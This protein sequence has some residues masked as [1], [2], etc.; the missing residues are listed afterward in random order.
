M[1]M[2]F[3]GVWGP[4]LDPVRSTGTTTTSCHVVRWSVATFPLAMNIVEMC[5]IMSPIILNYV[6][7]ITCLE[8]HLF[9][10]G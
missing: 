7:D 4:V 8:V 3:F 6:D 2:T 1:I 9:C 10:V 5:Y